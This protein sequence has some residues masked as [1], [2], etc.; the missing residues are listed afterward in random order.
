M[1]GK[2][3]ATRKQAMNA[4]PLTNRKTSLWRKAVKNRTLLLM[5][6]PA[7]AFFLAFSYIPMPGAYI[8]FTKFNY[9]KGIFGSDFIGFK[10]FE[11][12]FSSGQL[13][14]LL[15]NTVLYNLAFILLGNLLQLTFAILLGEVKSTVFKKVTQSMMFLP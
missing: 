12:L 13:A 11:F 5:C 4:S 8:A 7:I 15:R 1:T 3:A 2:A 10:N 9:N 14:L 6:L